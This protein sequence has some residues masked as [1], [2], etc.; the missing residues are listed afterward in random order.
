MS[1]LENTIRRLGV[2]PVLGDEGQ[3][4]WIEQS[5]YELATFIEAVQPLGIQTVLEVGTGWKSGLAR[6]MA[7]VLGWKVDSVDIHE[8]TYRDP[9]V[10]YH[11]TPHRPAFDHLFD[12]VIIDADHTYESVKADYEWYKA[13]AAKVILFH[14]IAGLRGCEGA[15]QFWKHLAAPYKDGLLEHGYHVIFDPNAP[16]RCGIGWVEL[17]KTAT[18]P[19]VGEIA[20]K[21]Q[22]IVDD[23]T[24]E[25]AAVPEDDV[26]LPVEDEPPPTQPRIETAPKKRGRPSKK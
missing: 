5:P 23:I 13:F 8:P 12:L 20:N 15:A 9:L 22:T 16:S 11:I 18:L 24:F 21:T 6:F 2:H 14:D 3:G 25:D 7:A 19:A 17:S 4:F 26:V 10:T 1:E